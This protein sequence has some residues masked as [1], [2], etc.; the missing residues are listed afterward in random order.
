MFV[1]PRED[2]ANDAGMHAGV[3]AREAFMARGVEH[4][5]ALTSFH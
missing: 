3:A 1:A 2:R 5:F 4:D